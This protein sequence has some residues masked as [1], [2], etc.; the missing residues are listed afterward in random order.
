MAGNKIN[1]KKREDKSKTLRN[2]N[3]GNEDTEDID[4]SILRKPIISSVTGFSQ[5]R[6]IF[7][8]ATEEIKSLISNECDLLYECKVCRNIFRSL[9]NFISH[10]RIYCREKFT[11]SEHGHFV[12]PSSLAHEVKKFN[13]LEENYRASLKTG[14]EDDSSDRIPLT[15]DLSEVIERIAKRKAVQ[16]GMIENQQVTLQKIPKSAVAV[17][18]SV[19]YDGKITDS[20]RAQVQELNRITS[21]ENAVLQKDG[22]F[23]IQNTLPNDP[24]NVIQISDDDDEDEDSEDNNVH[25]CKECDLQFTTLKTLKFHM[26]HKHLENRLVFPCP[27][28]LA[29]FST[30]WSVYR[31]LFKIH[32]KTAAQIRR[33]RE[34]I[35]SKAFRMNNPPAFY[36]KRKSNI[37]NA[38]QKKTEEERLDQE[39]QE[40][41]DNMEG[42]GELPRCGGCGRAF[43]R[44]A[45]L[46][47]HTN[48]CQPRSRALAR[49]PQET[50]KIEIQ[51][52]KDYNKGPPTS[53]VFTKSENDI[54]DNPKEVAATKPVPTKD[55]IDVEENKL[56]EA[57]MTVIG[58]KEENME[59]DTD[60]A[61]IEKK[62]IT[63]EN[64]D[65][66]QDHKNMTQENKDTLLVNKDTTHDNKDTTQENKDT[67]QENEDALQDDKDMS[68]EKKFLNRLPYAYG[69]E[70]RN[71]DAL[72]QKMNQDVEL[73]S[74][75]CKKCDTKCVDK[76][77][78][79]DHMAN[80]YKWIRYG[81]K[82]CNFKHYE[83]DKLPEHIKIV[84]KLKGDSDFYFSTVKAI[85]SPEALEIT[86]LSDDV[87]E[88]TATSPESRRPSRCSSD[89][90]RMSD[91]SSS[92]SVRIEGSRKRKINRCRT[93]TK[94]FKES[95]G[96]DKSEDPK[97]EE[98]KP[99]IIDNESSSNS[100]TFEENSSDMDDVETDK[101]TKIITNDKPVSVASRRPVRKKTKPKNEDFEYDLSNLLKLEAQG[102]RDS[103]L[104]SSN[105]T[106]T[107]KKKMQ[108]NQNAFDNLNKECT[109]A[110]VTL[111]RKSV[112]KSK[113]VMKNSSFAFNSS[114]KRIVNVFAKPYTPKISKTDKSSPKKDAIESTNDQSPTKEATAAEAQAVDTK[115]TSKTTHASEVQNYNE[116]SQPETDTMTQKESILEKYETP[117]CSKNEPDTSKESDTK[118][119]VPNEKDKSNSNVNVSKIFPIKFGRGIDV[120]KNPLIKKNLTDFTKAGMKTKI[121]VIKPINRSKDGANSIN[122]PLKFQTIKI[123]DPNK[124][125]ANEEKKTDQSVIAPVPKVECAIRPPSSLSSN[126]KGPL[127]SITQSFENNSDVVNTTTEINDDKSTKNDAVKSSDTKSNDNSDIKEQE[128]L[129]PENTKS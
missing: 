104:S 55:P 1:T 30:S 71:L 54:K 40:W 101:S 32:R 105:K 103:L 118:D 99:N 80:H 56:T 117:N 4:F 5:A 13:K 111:S 34:S 38:P 6:K 42:D 51:I 9:V 76:G 60:S 110:L 14:N 50:K 72:K 36:E 95:S 15:K 24:E 94:K 126:E 61:I 106:Y 27:D 102:Y 64:K 116:K 119:T 115:D 86:E 109:G 124:N 45:A 69:A 59:I 58:D 98:M 37:K 52:R 88:T 7:D 53:M 82:L 44:L 22:K 78:L 112:E 33:L 68:Q 17:Y 74:F 41:M 84:H 75:L 3:Q 28:C 120:I 67:T 23:K 108:D 16:D 10:K 46:V 11:A 62:D 113:A 20:L 90:S 91:D 121:L 128:V 81:C 89:S 127:P 49:R 122:T 73:D 83:F 66:W 19:N 125:K 97:E 31:H 2:A 18:Q 87:S 43:A 25:E 48:T 8:V 65:T 93:N 129:A 92:S 26:K 77:A 79:I 107:S 85:D 39:N 123:K 12:R 47:A 29:I 63:H 114:S 100:K 21:M 57:V 70:K 96:L 35:Q